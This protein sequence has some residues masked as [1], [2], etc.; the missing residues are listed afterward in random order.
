MTNV[1]VCEHQLPH[2]SLWRG[3]SLG[4]LQGYPNVQNIYFPQSTTNKASDCIS[5]CI[6]ANN[7]N[8]DSTL[9][10]IKSTVDLGI[11]ITRYQQ[12]ITVAVPWS[13]PPGIRE[14]PAWR[15][16]VHWHRDQKYVSR[17]FPGS[18]KHK[19]ASWCS[20]KRKVRQ[21]HQYS[22]QSQSIFEVWSAFAWH[23]LGI[24]N[25]AIRSRISVIH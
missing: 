3:V 9:L 4:F 25:L 2:N 6:N 13:R 20:V 5:D 14:R 22:Y 11:N 24:I 19:W 12:V 8:L 7:M 1:S 17:Q 21:S 16:P 18:I 15:W 23:Q 10:D